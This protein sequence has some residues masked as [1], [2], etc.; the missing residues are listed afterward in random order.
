LQ[1]RRCGAA[2]EAGFDLGFVS[3]HGPR[4]TRR[5]MAWRGGVSVN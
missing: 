4:D 5:M 2:R 3:D 1:P